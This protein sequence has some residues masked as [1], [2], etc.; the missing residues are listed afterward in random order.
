VSSCRCWRRRECCCS[1]WSWRRRACWT[2]RPASRRTTG[3]VAEVL[4]KAGVISLHSGC[5]RR[6]AASHR[7]VDHVEATTLPLIQSELE[8]GTA[9]PGEILCPPLNVEDTVGSSTTYRCEDAE[10]TINQIQVVPVR[11]DRVVVVDPRQALVGKACIGCRKLGIAIGRQ[12][13]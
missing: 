4:S 10:S 11:E 1:G 7:A 2:G 6:V 8:V 9:A 3:S 12:V 13:D 5:G